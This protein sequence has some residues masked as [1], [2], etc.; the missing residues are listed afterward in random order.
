MLSSLLWTASSSEIP[1]A[2]A[3]GWIKTRCINGGMIQIYNN[4]VSVMIKVLLLAVLL[5][6]TIAQEITPEDSTTIEKTREKGTEEPEI[7]KVRKNKN[8]FDPTLR[9]NQPKT[10]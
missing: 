3:R 4:S 10:H 1:E 9:K 6:G 7:P 5:L 2:N 8:P